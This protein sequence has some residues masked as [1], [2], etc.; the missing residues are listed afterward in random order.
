V[1][2]G[3]AEKF[4]R[5]SKKNDEG[6]TIF[7]AIN[8]KEA[9]NGVWLVGRLLEGW[10]HEKGSSTSTGG[11]IESLRLVGCCF[12]CNAGWLLL[13][14]QCGDVDVGKESL[15]GYQRCTGYCWWTA[16]VLMGEDA[17]W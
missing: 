5:L 7:A 16:A 4:E 3:A 2:D 11:T 15:P 8:R 1:A 6:D 13:L 14:L 9:A 17:I 10:E 12:Y